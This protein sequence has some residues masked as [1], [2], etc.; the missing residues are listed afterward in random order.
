MLWRNMDSKH[1]TLIDKAIKKVPSRL[2]DDAFQAGCL[3]LLVG[4]RNLDKVENQDGYLYTCIRNAVM[5]E[6]ASLHN[7]YCL[8]SRTLSNLAKYKKAK[9][10]GTRSE[11]KLATI[12]QLEK[13]LR[14]S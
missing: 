13:I 7:I 6:M 12:E 11:M 8:D 3:G 5:N 14:N 9:A 2:R 10:Y 4:L 1:K